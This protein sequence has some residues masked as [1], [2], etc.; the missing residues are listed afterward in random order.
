MALCLQARG[1]WRSPGDLKLLRR[2]ERER[3][4]GLAPLGL[5]MDGLQQ[6]FIRTEAPLQTLRNWGMRNF[7]RSGL[8]K[9]WAARQAMGLM[10]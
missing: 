2:Y 3:K 9:D 5:A 4:A 6:L 1:E 7:E 8:L 10:R